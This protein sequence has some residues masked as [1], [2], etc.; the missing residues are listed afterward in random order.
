MILAIGDERVIAGHGVELR[1]GGG[2]IALA[3]LD[4]PR[5]EPAEQRIDPVARC[6]QHLGGGGG[7]KNEWGFQCDIC[8]HGLGPRGKED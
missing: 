4:P 3:D 6:L 5:H 2:E 1:L 7:G 8:R